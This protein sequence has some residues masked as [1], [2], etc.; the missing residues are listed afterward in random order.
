L[1]STDNARSTLELFKKAMPAALR[2][3]VD[4]GIQ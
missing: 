3:R 4:A 2:G 1:A